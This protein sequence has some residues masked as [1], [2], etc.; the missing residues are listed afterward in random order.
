MAYVS[1]F[2][3]GIFVVLPIW[4]IM[5]AIGARSKIW[6]AGLGAISSALYADPIW[7]SQTIWCIN[8]QMI[9]AS[10]AAGTIGGLV[11][12]RVSLGEQV[13]AGASPGENG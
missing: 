5:Y 10:L 3:L 13:L 8:D 2:S 9:I 1:A 11:F 7:C 4:M 6:L 12:Y